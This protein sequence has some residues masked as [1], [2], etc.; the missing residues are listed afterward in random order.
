MSGVTVL[1]PYFGLGIKEVQRVIA[2]FL[3]L[4][5]RTGA[6]ELTQCSSS[7]TWHIDF[8]HLISPSLVVACFAIY[9]F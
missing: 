7:H 1:L 2:A 5:H 3:F 4:L 6:E 9:V 8:S